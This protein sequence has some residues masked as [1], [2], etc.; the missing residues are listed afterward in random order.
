M[1]TERILY[2]KGK[3]LTVMALGYE[4]MALENTSE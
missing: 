4:Q 2:G 1:I 3:G